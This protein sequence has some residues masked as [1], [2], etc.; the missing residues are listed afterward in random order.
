MQT[1]VS[2]NG[3]GKVAKTTPKPKKSLFELAQTI[4]HGRYKGLSKIL[5]P[6]EIPKDR[7]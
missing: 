4:P 2:N 7:K 3:L 6:Y 1:A 5:E